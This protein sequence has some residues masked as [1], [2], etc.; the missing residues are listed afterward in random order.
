VKRAGR[1]YRLIPTHDNLRLAFWRA[2]RGKG[3]RHEV[4]DFRNDFDGNMSKLRDQLLKNEPDIGH[5]RFF[6]VRDP[7]PRCICAASF[8][9]RV[10]HHA[11]M[12]ICEPM[13]E[14]YAIHDVCMPEGKRASQGAFKSPVIRRK[15]LLVS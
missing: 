8:P 6:R 11:V 12:N 1:L 7:K 9:E 3:D 2:A 13:L 10:L 5:Y 15:V 4:I 14:S